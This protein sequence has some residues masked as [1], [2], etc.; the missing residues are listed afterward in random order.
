M[1]PQVSQELH[2][3]HVRYAVDQFK[4][5]E[6]D[7]EKPIGI[8]DDGCLAVVWREGKCPNAAAAG[9]APTRSMFN[10]VEWLQS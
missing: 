8:G 5:M 7:F 1:S 4:R 6:N 2:N 9:Q 10:S 3:V